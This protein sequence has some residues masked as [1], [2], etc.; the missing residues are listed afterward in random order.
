M[1]FRGSANISS[2][3]VIVVSA[4]DVVGWLGVLNYGLMWMT[5]R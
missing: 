1:S 2:L 5:A 4:A 3:S